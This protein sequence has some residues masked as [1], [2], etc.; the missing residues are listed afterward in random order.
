MNHA[1]ITIV[2]MP[3]KTYHIKTYEIETKFQCQIIR[4][5]ILVIILKELIS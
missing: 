3:H 1:E 4:V 5:I 2:A